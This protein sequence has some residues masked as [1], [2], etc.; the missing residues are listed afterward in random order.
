MPFRVQFSV[1]DLQSAAIHE[2]KKVVQRTAISHGRPRGLLHP[3]GHLKIVEAEYC[4]SRCYFRRELDVLIEFRVDR[5]L[6]SAEATSI[7]P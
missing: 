7:N 6:P 5:V 4:T 3:I 1:T 2:H